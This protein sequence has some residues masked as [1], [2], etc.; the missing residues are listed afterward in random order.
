M[1]F[2]ITPPGTTP[3]PNNRLPQSVGA[4]LAVA[5]PVGRGAL[6]VKQVPLGY[7]PPLCRG[8]RPRQPAS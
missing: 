2:T 6:A 1:S 7:T 4:T 5:L 8:W 3:P